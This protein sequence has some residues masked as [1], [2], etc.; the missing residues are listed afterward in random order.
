GEPAADGTV[1]ARPAARR[2][3][4]ADRPARAFASKEN[5]HDAVARGEAGDRRHRGE[6]VGGGRGAQDGRFGERHAARMLAW[7]APWEP[8]R[9][10]CGELPDPPAVENC[11]TVAGAP[12]PVT[13]RRVNTAQP[14]AKSA[15]A[16][17]HGQAIAASHPFASGSLPYA[18]HSGEN[19]RSHSTSGDC[20]PTAFSR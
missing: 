14:A 19:P 4:H 3:I 10:I 1:A 6:E 20:A 2:H 13:S 11:R 9:P 15:T 7:R 16:T 12:Q 5:R 17:A 18:H 8:R